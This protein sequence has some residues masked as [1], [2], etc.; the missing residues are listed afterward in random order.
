M[1]SGIIR[2]GLLGCGAITR[3][4]HLP[5]A[6]AHP[7]VHV[8]AL[9][10]SDLGRAKL[11]QESYGLDCWVGTDCGAAIGRVDAVINAL[12]NY[13]H[14]PVSLELLSAGI[15]VLCEKPL[16]T[17]SE[18]VRACHLQAVQKGLV[19]AVGM[20][21]RFQESTELMQLLLREGLLGSV[22]GYD[23]EN[24]M[25]FDWRTAS[26]FYFSPAQ[27]GGGVLLDEGIHFLDCLLHWFGPARCLEYLDDNWGGVEANVKAHFRHEG[28]C[29]GLKG[30]LRLSRTYSLKNRLLV[31]G[32]EAYAEIPRGD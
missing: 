16:A 26:G 23:W 22:V 12:P 32:T 25:P 3:I 18:A 10:D 1:N 19:L 4:R 29:G 7:Y 2:L 9:V 13:L 15:H 30:S 21:R 6:V 20:P 5:S 24:G 27:A 31:Y 28:P 17:D 8:T 14:A 11:L